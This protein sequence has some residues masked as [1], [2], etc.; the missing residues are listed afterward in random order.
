MNFL[1]APRKEFL[2]FSCL[3]FIIICSQSFAIT[4]DPIV[5]GDYIG[6]TVKFLGIQEDSETDSI[7]D[8]FGDPL[9]LYG[10]PTYSGGDELEFDNL[11]FNASSV[12]GGGG[13]A[14]YEQ[15]ITDGKLS[16]S[17]EAKPQAYIDKLNFDEYGDVTISG[18]GGDSVASV[19]NTIFI[20]FK[21]VD[22]API[23]DFTVPVSMVFTP[24]DS[25]QRTIDG[26]MTGQLWSGSLDIDLTQ[27]LR[28]NEID[29]GFATLID[30]AMDNTLTA[31]STTGSSAFIAK[32]QT[33]GLKITA[34]I[35]PE[36][37]TIALLGFGSLIALR[38]K[39]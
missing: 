35:I 34:E 33:D 7:Y 9:G 16:G 28:D 19:S 1:K 15:D 10:E 27:I 39:R 3:I 36:P 2:A 26:S 31:E 38:R 13:G 5:Y 32:K 23:S 20:K 6:V 12:N 22:H 25:W 24:D 18:L 8:E 4:Q 21:E 17:I 14:G 29:E 30:F 11:N 37:A